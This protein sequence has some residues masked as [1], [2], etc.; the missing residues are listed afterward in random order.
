M[1]RRGHG[2]PGTGALKTHRGQTQTNNTCPHHRQ[3]RPTPSYSPR[4]HLWHSHSD[5]EKLSQ[6]A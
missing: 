3:P 5:V 1:I 2:T 4:P 6:L